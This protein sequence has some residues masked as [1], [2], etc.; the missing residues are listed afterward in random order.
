MNL[1]NL[2][3]STSHLMASAV[4]EIWPEVKVTIGP[5]IE[6]GFYYDFDFGK[7]KI[8]ESDFPKIESTMKTIVKDWKEIKGEKVTS[9]KAKELFRENKYKL[10]LIKD[11]I[12]DGEKIKVY[13]SGDFTDLCGGGHV[14]NP[15]KEL[16][17][18][19][20]LS[21]AGAYW[22]GSEKNKMLTRIYGTVFPTKKE[23]DSHLEM[24]KEAK[25]RD[26]RKIGKE[27]NLF[28]FSDLV[29]K[30]LPLLTEKG[31]TI[32]REIERFVVDE[33]IKRGYKHVKTP[34]IAKTDL[35]KKSGHYPYYK[36][37]MYP[38]MKV[39]NEELI[40]RPMTCPHHFELYR[41]LPR[42]YREFPIRFAE[43]ANLYRYEKS[44]ELSGL[45]RVREFTLADSHNFVR[46]EN[47]DK[48]INFVLDLIEDISDMFGL[49]K[50]KDY[51]Y[52]LSLGD[53]KNKEKYFDSPKDWEFG[54]K[55]LKSVLTK[56]KA[57]FVEAEDEAAFYGPKIDVQ[58]KNVSGNEDTA[59]TVQYD[60]CLPSKFK[61]EYIN[62]KGEKEQP[63][64]IHRSSVG[65]MERT[66][67]FL[68]EH[69]AGNFPVWLSPIQVKILPITKDQTDYAKEVAE[70]FR[71]ENIRVEVD[72]RSETLQA[73]IRDAQ[74]EKVPYM[75]IVGKKEEKVKKVAIRDRSGKD[76][77]AVDTNT[78]IEKTRKIIDE[79]SLQL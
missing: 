46:K 71:T 64:V 26:H 52:R 59:F 19:K 9:E 47:A 11:L 37:S 24:L 3:H 56:R 4:K 16:V 70:K 31:T 76:L 45:M 65:A 38:P 28:T 29:G 49:K 32:W 23:L 7:E 27:L 22:K 43:M 35:Y 36:D 69:Y 62:E 61:L 39:E 67:A 44:G 1:N 60:F 66:M 8:S 74:I 58:M 25:K 41:S 5:S 79:K 34:N 21:V 15:S 50:G 13:R 18:F 17:H 63:V 2:R 48:E 51:S 14:E 42:S 78:F 53:L 20:L 12:K 77:G 40:L 6:N 73:K 30:G 55:L 68:I 57:P 72:V 33:E 75:A 54:E 10:E